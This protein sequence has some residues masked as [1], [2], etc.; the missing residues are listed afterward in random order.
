MFQ[1]TIDQWIIE[2]EANL[3]GAVLVLTQFII[4]C[5]GCEGHKIKLDWYL[6]IST[7]KTVVSNLVNWMLKNYNETALNDKNVRLIFIKISNFY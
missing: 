7:E 2:S 4:T 5:C 6:E 1:E 3:D